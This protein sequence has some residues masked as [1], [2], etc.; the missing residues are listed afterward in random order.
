[1]GVVFRPENPW[2]SDGIDRDSEGLLAYTAGESGPCDPDPDQLLE[3]FTPV[4]ED[5][6]V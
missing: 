6:E 5:A 3:P 4:I 2:R 1:M